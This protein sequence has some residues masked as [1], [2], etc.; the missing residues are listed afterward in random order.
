MGPKQPPEVN[1]LEIQSYTQTAHVPPA[2]G[3]FAKFP[4][5]SVEKPFVISQPSPFRLPALAT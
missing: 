1:V 5:P 3:V 2:R 4:S